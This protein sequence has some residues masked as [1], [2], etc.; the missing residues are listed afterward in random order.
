MDEPEGESGTY[1]NPAGIYEDSV[2]LDVGSSVSPT[3]G[4]KDSELLTSS[5]DGFRISDVSISHRGVH[6]PEGVSTDEITQ[7][8]LIQELIDEEG[9]L[10]TGYEY[11]FITYR[12]TNE[13]NTEE[14]FMLNSARLFVIGNEYEVLGGGEEVCYLNGKDLAANEIAKDKGIARET[15]GLGESGTY[16]VAF[17]IEK[18]VTSKGGLYFVPDTAPGVTIGDPI[19]PYQAIKVEN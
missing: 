17:F 15:L 6:L 8:G 16:T 2:L 5:M 12:L 14:W 3:D 7:G 1:F 19:R 18:S 11:V 4:F 10:S 13:T 9:T